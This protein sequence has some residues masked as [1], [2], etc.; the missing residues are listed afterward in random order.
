MDEIL[1][2]MASSCPVIYGLILNV[3]TVETDSNTQL[4]LHFIAH[5]MREKYYF[6]TTHTHQNICSLMK[7]LHSE[8]EI[9]KFRCLG[10]VRLNQCC[11]RLQQREKKNMKTTVKNITS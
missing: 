6:A 2:T 9:D 11:I 5:A 4:A 8:D 10:M 1:I 3:Y 7:S